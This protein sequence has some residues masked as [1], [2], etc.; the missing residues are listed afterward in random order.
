MLRRGA[1]STQAWMTARQAD[2]GRMMAPY[3]PVDD[4]NR[5]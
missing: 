2:A 1:G 4:V 3:W 5:L